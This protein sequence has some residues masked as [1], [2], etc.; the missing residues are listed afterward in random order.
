VKFGKQVH[1]RFGE[2]RSHIT[3]KE[4]FFWDLAATLVPLRQSTVSILTRQSLI[5]RVKYVSSLSAVG[6]ALQA[7][8]HPGFPREYLLF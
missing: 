3:T 7:E 4:V 5:S 2:S 1:N 6:P 8:V